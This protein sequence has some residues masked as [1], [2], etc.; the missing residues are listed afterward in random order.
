MLTTTQQNL[1]DS[2]T[3]YHPW[4]FDDPGDEDHNPETE[5]ALD[6]LRSLGLVTRLGRDAES[7][8]TFAPTDKGWLK[9]GHQA[10]TER[11][12]YCLHEMVDYSERQQ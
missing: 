2:I 12:E 8:R 11:L 6:Q 1:L 7:R 4:A 3:A 10:R 9:A 5:E